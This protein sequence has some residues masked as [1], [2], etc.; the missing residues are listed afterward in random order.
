MQYN[1][2][3]EIFPDSLIASGYGFRAETMWKSEE[4]DAIRQNVRVNF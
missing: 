1:I 2:K 3:R 4:G